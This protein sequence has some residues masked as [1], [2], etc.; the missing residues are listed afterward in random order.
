MRRFFMLLAFVLLV[1]VPATAVT[2][3]FYA[4]RDR[5][6]CISP[7]CGG[8]FLLADDTEDPCR[9]FKPE[10]YVTGIYVERGPALIP[11]QPSCDEII[12]GTTFSDP[13]FPD[14]EIFIIERP[15]RDTVNARCQSDDECDKGARCCYPCGIADC[16][17]ICMAVGEDGE[18]P[19]YR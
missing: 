5:R 17:N 3:D 11:V 4:Q 1:S 16:E 12:S 15:G 18:C 13:Y 7:Y 2:G 9:L 14:F 19:L 6:R 10:I 8:Y